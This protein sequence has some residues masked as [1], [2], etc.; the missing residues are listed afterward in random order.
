MDFTTL[1]IM[2]VGLVLF[3]VGVRLAYIENKRVM[4]LLMKKVGEPSSLF[5]PLGWG[6]RDYKKPFL[7]FV[8]IILGFYLMIFDIQNILQLLKERA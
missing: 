1:I 5:N 4:R 7:Y 8:M 2:L 3:I 6:W